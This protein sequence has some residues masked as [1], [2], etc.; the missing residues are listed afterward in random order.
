MWA[1]SQLALTRWPNGY[2]LDGGRVAFFV[3][4]FASRGVMARQS[5]PTPDHLASHGRFF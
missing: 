3:M 1:G 5:Q 2:E 4:A